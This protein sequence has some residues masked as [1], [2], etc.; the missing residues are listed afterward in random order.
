MSG[1]GF[2]IKEICKFSPIYPVINRSSIFIIFAIGLAGILVIFTDKI[3]EWF[4]RGYILKPELLIVGAYNEAAFW[5]LMPLLSLLTIVYFN[6][7]TRLLTENRYEG[8]LAEIQRRS[9]SYKGNYLSSLKIMLAMSLTIMIIINTLSSYISENLQIAPV[10][11]TISLGS[12]FLSINIFNSIVLR[13]LGRIRIAKISL[14][15]VVAAGILSFPF[16][17]NNLEFV[18]IGFLSGSLAGLIISCISVSMSFSNFEH[19]I[20]RLLQNNY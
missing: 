20:F 4:D 14:I 9:S 13:G 2:D 15:A 16:A 11:F 7:R 1:T 10:L 17:I 3:I 8:T 18:S 12:V 19:N 5:G 6:R